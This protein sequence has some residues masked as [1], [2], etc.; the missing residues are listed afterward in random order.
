MKRV[1][2]LQNYVSQSLQDARL[3]TIRQR[4][5]HLNYSRK[6]PEW[7]AM[8]FNR[9]K[10][11][12][13]CFV[14]KCATISWQRILLKL[15]GNPTAIKI[16]NTRGR[17]IPVKL[18]L[19]LGSMA[20]VNASSRAS[21]MK[22]NYK[23]LFVRDPLVRL[24]SAYRGNILTD[25]EYQRKIKRLTRPTGSHRYN[26]T[27]ISLAVDNWQQEIE[28]EAKLSAKNSAPQSRSLQS[29]RQEVVTMSTPYRTRHRAV[30]L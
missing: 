18:I 17:R 9:Q 12:L 3:L 29:S 5:L 19:Y 16:A 11:V 8:I 13:M 27:T 30:P 1:L 7:R 21:F 6:E 15:T 28:N 25:V 22:E 10:H 4:C 20:Y 23:I 2:L 14:G 24:I 26:R